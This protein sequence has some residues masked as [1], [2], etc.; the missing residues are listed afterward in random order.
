MVKMPLSAVIMTAEVIDSS[1]LLKISKDSIVSPFL[2]MV[3]SSVA[4]CNYNC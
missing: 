3:N 1:I 4:T 2:N